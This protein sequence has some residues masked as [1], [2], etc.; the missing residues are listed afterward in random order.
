MW[1]P[2]ELMCGKIPWTCF[3]GIS[4]V[5]IAP[6]IVCEIFLSI[7]R[8]RL[9]MT[10]F[11]QVWFYLIICLE[12]DKLWISHLHIS[13]E[14]AL[15]A[16]WGDPKRKLSLY[17]WTRRGGGH[18]HFKWQNSYNDYADAQDLICSN[19]REAGYY[20]AIKLFHFLEFKEKLL[21]KE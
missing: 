17:F 20:K 18:L 19:E 14:I 16:G 4:E 2:V 7:F 10:A 15:W 13:F 5:E 1:F 12:S 9:S 21:Y 11:W 3:K 8:L 6:M